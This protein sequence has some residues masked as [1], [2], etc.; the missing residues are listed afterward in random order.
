ML[1][2]SYSTMSLSLLSGFPGFFQILSM[3]ILTV[4]SLKILVACQHL[5]STAFF[6]FTFY[7]R[8][9]LKLLLYMVVSYFLVQ[10]CLYLFS[11]GFYLS[12]FQHQSCSRQIL[13]FF[14]YKFQLLDR[15]YSS[16][17]IVQITWHSI[18][19]YH[20][21]SFFLFRTIL[22]AKNFKN[23]LFNQLLCP[24]IILKCIELYLLTISLQ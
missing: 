14:I 9:Q 1:L 21:F 4:L 13:I 6:L 3:A 15:L 19:F 8:L 20:L 7:N 10:F 5:N 11:W 18:C 24:V 2:A 17:Q 16:I 12:S 23:H 22:R